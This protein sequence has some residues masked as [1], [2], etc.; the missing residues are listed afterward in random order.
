M[1]NKAVTALLVAV[2][3]GGGYVAMQNGAKHGS[4]LVAPEKPNQIPA[5]GQ[6]LAFVNSDCVNCKRMQENLALLK[7][8]VPIKWVYVD[9]DRSMARS[10]KIRNPP[11]FVRVDD[12]DR[13]ISRTSGHLSVPDMCRWL[14]LPLPAPQESVP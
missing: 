11:V 1:D 4:P 13:E 3:L 9:V 8:P 7:I 5:R 6:I 14:H 12:F 2:A 10:Y